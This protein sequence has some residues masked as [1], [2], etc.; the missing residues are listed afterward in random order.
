MIASKPRDERG[1][2]APMVGIMVVI[3]IG[4][5]SFA[6]DIGYQRVAAR[7]MQAVADVVAFDM[8]RGLDGRSSSALVGSNWTARLTDS[9]NR[10]RDSVGES[11]TVV[12]CSASTTTLSDAQICATPGVYDRAT[13][14]F[15][16][17]NGAAATHV[18]VITRTYVDRFFPIYD[19]SGWVTKT[20]YA[21][22]QKK[23]CIQL[24]SYAAR[25]KA[26]QSPLLGPLL[27]FLDTDLNLGVGDYNALA[28]VNLDLLNLV[29]V[30]TSAGTIGELIEG[31]KLLGLADFY[32]ATATAL[33]QQSGNTAA[34]GLLQAL[35]VKVPNL[36]I[37]LGEL[38]DVGTGGASGLDAALNLLDL[39]S[40]AAFVANGD[41]AVTI[42]QLNV[43]L[44]PLAKVQ[45]KAHITEPLRP[46]CND[47]IAK[48]SQVGV[49]LDA[50]ALD[51]SFVPLGVLDPLG[52]TKIETKIALHGEINVG[53]AQGTITNAKCRPNKSVTVK[54]SD[55]L[56]TVNLSLEIKAKFGLLGVIE[57]PITVTGS[58]PTNGEVTKVIINDGDYDIALPV[59]NGNIG[60]PIL[61]VNTSQLKVLNL[62][63]GALLGWVLNPILDLLINP[64]LQGLDKF[65]LSPLL[66]TLGLQVSG[67]DVFVLREPNCGTPA[68]RG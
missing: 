27:G 51:F 66:Q 33:Q 67:A 16:D 20:A 15:S 45:A 18:R 41:N 37:P 17:S 2:V 26:G 43:N 36:K 55:G 38:L 3:L 39:V 57:G 19:E 34:V 61:H 44:G 40:T 22:A 32:L 64:L 62:P 25:L 28:A 1:A 42:P 60:L 50:T 14:T 58:A 9:V 53:A 11:L 68:L 24:G 59:G 7:D 49:T 6:V 31:N 4:M 46:A 35:A 65:V 30:N 48:T 5:A 63:V 47:G 13:K 54:V 10:N 56:A 52:L 12:S 29:D 8:A 21:E 23:V